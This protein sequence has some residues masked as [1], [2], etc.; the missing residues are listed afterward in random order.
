MREKKS[1][2]DL[3]DIRDVQIDKSQPK[4][5]RLAEYYR[6]LNGHE[7]FKYKDKDVRVFFTKG[8]PPIEDCLIGLIV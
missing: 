8:G 4:T 7:H 6:Q 5:K 1:I 3:V 2:A